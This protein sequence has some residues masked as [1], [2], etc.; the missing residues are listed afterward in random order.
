MGKLRRAKNRLNRLNKK[1]QKSEMKNIEFKNLA[2]QKGTYVSQNEILTVM[3]YLNQSIRE[4]IPCGSNKAP[5]EFQITEA[6]KQIL[7]GLSRL[8]KKGIIHGNLKAE[9]IMR[10]RIESDMSSFIESDISR[11]FSLE[12]TEW[13]IVDYR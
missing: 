5:E 3:E 2:Q 11:E 12:E 8:H 13:K 10:A 6:L 4:L 7:N 9:N 1:L